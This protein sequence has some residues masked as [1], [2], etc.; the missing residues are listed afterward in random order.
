MKWCTVC[1]SSVYIYLFSPMFWSGSDIT[2]GWEPLLWCKQASGISGHQRRD[3]I[4]EM[5][6]FSRKSAAIIISSCAQQLTIK[7]SRMQE[8]E[9][10]VYWEGNKAARGHTV[11]WIYTGYILDI[12]KHTGTFSPDS[13]CSSSA[14]ENGRVNLL[15]FL[16]IEKE[17]S[18]Y[19]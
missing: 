16:L 15:I 6:W 9:P 13:L 2:K 3:D 5:C 1:N 19:F 7:G 10:L 4:N 18:F 11:Y 14:R 12:C 17:A 8:E